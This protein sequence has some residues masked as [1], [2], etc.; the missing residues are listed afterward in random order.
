M[1]IKYLSDYPARSEKSQ[2]PIVSV[3][4]CVRNGAAGIA[5]TIQSVSAQKFPSLEYIIV[6]GAS[7]DG[8][9][10]IIRAH[11]QDVDFW[12]SEPDAGISD[13]LNKGI[14]LTQGRFIALVH[15]DDWL[16]PNQIALSVETLEITG[17]DFVFGDLTLHDNDGPAHLLVGDAEYRRH[18]A[19]GMPAL[20]HPTVVMRRTAYEAHGLFDTDYRLAMDYE[21]LLRFH[22]AGLKGV[23]DRRLMGHMSLEGASDQHGIKASAEVRRASIRHGYPPLLANLRFVYRA[24]KTLSRRLLQQAMPTQHISFVRRIVNSSYRELR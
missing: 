1:P 7:T 23:Y 12:H 24:V 6:D 20:N 9:L 22:R 15:S 10:D 5:R 16:A 4:T 21:L 11:A 17:A 3:V 19:H 8:T 13:G 2:P 18:I 14:A